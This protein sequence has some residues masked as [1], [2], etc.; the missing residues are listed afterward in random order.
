MNEAWFREL[1]LSCHSHPSKRIINRVWGW[2]GCPTQGG[3]RC[4][5]SIALI[6]GNQYKSMVYFVQKQ[7]EEHKNI[8]SD[9]VRW[10]GFLWKK[11]VACFASCN[12]ENR[13]WREISTGRVIGAR[14]DGVAD[15]PQ[16][17][18][19]PPPTVSCEGSGGCW[20]LQPCRFLHTFV[21]YLSC[22]AL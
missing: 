13:K 17:C 16:R 4:I 14:V 9:Q 5:R 15:K 1:L 6:A 3:S 21:D 12:R 10:S 18:L 22:V 8:Q 7:W 2:G 11:G 19:P 20:P